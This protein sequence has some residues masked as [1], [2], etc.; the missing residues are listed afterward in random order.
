[1]NALEQLI[2][3][4]PLFWLD[5]S[6]QGLL[7]DNTT[8]DDE[9][10]KSTIA[11]IM[12][13]LYQWN[14]AYRAGSPLVDDSVYDATDEFLRN[15]LGVEEEDTHV[16]IPDSDERK[17]KLPIV[18]ASM[19]KCKTLAELKK[20]ADSKNF[21]FDSTEFVISAKL[22]GIT[23]VVEESHMR[24]GSPLGQIK[25]WTKGRDGMGLFVP[26]HFQV[27]N[28]GA[29]ISKNQ[30]V[31]TRGEA[32]MRK[33]T[34]ADKKYVR[35]ETGKPYEN[36][37]NLVSGKFTDKQPEKEIVENIDYIRFHLDTDGS[38]W[39]DK[40]DQIA[41][42]NMHNVV[43]LPHVLIEGRDITEELLYNLFQQFGMIYD[44]DGLI[45][46]VNSAL[47]RRQLGYETSTNNPCFARAFK[48]EFE[49]VQETEVVEVRRQIS[50]Q[51][52]LKP[53]LGIKP[54]RLDGAT[55]TSIFVDNERWIAAYGIGVGSRIKVKRS[56]MVIPR[57][58]EVEGVK[59]LSAK[60]FN[61][62]ADK[63]WNAFTS[64]SHIKQSLGLPVHNYMLPPEFLD[65]QAKWNENMIEIVMNEV[66]DDI[67]IQ[68]NIAFFEILEADGIS[69][70][71]ITDLYT[72]GYKTVKDIVGLVRPANFPTKSG[73]ADMYNWDGW[74]IKRA[75]TVA[76]SINKALENA[77]L[78]NLQHASGCF[79]GLGSSKLQ[80]VL[81]KY[82]NEK[83]TFD[84]LLQ[85]DG[86]SNISAEAYLDGYENFCVMMYEAGIKI[87]EKK[88]TMTNFTEVIVFTGF[89]DKELEQYITGKG[90]KVVSSFTK[91][92]TI[93]VTKDTS[94]NSSKI[95]KARKNGT[96]IIGA[97]DFKKE[98]GYTAN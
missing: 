45:I 49:E 3:R 44:I 18:A 82:Y 70:G 52:Y 46:E 38:D 83:P 81:D 20:W 25:A 95:E 85:I 63:N 93:L 19:N 1:M 35:K 74:G 12:E 48:G 58:I 42:L 79:K 5:E 73:V 84:Q 17:Q 66:T 8:T 96:K 11:K 98:I 53:V 65:G 40:L 97:E 14:K 87:P 41:V 16:E 30:S 72:K 15:T 89:R 55:V 6:F 94:S 23:L 61:K 34:F 69:D 56:G 9:L 92:V 60:E 36:T 39:M 21:D 80:W 32:V 91:E 13:Q 78:A 47:I 54:V 57:V 28:T 26:E 10:W 2:E 33:K 7:Y 24:K 77:T 59:V 64:D 51:G 37:R 27:M 71:I 86:Y 4:D 68:R 75:N 29:T 88:E 67:Q 22:D 31:I 76:D 62:W 50:K 43:A 90:Y